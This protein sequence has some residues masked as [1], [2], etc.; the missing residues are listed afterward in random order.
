MTNQPQIKS[1]ILHLDSLEILDK[2]SD[3]QA[4]KLFKAIH[5]YQKNN[6]YPQLDFALDLVI[7]PFINQFKR[8]KEKWEN[9]IKKKSDKGKIGNLKRW[10]KEIYKRFMKCEL[11]LDEAIKIATQSSR[12]VNDSQQSPPIPKSLKNKSDSKNKNEK[13][14]I[15]NFIDQIL[16]DEFLN[17][18]KKDKNEVGVFAL[19]LI[20]EDLQKWE[21]EKQGNANIALKNAIKGGWKSL[22]EPRPNNNQPQ[23][24]KHTFLTKQQ[25]EQNQNMQIFSNLQKKYGGENA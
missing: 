10:H 21:N 7:S 6:A 11:T 19:K 9:E 24:P 17:Q 25:I 13:I 23:Q 12:I 4:G 1:F 2:L 3:E 16:L 14:N 8:D 18:R 15:P 22:V 20:F 5:S